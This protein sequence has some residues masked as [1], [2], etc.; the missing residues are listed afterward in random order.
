MQIK[1]F[2][3]TVNSSEFKEMIMASLKCRTWESRYADTWKDIADFERREVKAWSKANPLQQE[4]RACE[5]M[6]A[7]VS[8]TD[9]I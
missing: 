6:K 1:T 5:R 7:Y 3:K 8:L 4:A 2:L 9:R